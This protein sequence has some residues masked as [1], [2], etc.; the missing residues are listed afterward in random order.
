MHAP[1]HDR[2]HGFP[3]RDEAVLFER[4]LLEINQ[5]GLSWATVLRKRDTLRAAYAGFEVDRVAAFTDA[6][7]QRLM[8]D[9]GVI[10]NARKVDAAIANARAVQGL[11]AGSGGF[12]AFLDA[13]HPR[14]K[15]DWVKLLKRHFIHVGGEIAGEFLMSLGYLPGAHRPDCPVHARV[16]AADPPWRHARAGTFD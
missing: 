1:Y 5:A 2:E 6:D 9:P 10:R 11:R 12:A 3:A 4:L 15:A 13:Q 14:P 16:L 8:A 7:R